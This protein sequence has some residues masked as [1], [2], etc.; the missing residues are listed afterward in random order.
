MFFDRLIENLELSDLHKVEFRSEV[1]NFSIIFISSA[2]VGPRRFRVA[3]FETGAFF[4]YGFL[5]DN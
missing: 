4:N 3:I 2:P 1:F 5:I